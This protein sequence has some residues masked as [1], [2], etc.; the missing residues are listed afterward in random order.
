MLSLSLPTKHQVQERREDFSASL[1]ID[2]DA[3]EVDLGSS[4]SH[5]QYTYDLMIY[6]PTDYNIILVECIVNYEP[7]QLPIFQLGYCSDM[8]FS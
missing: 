6:L 8:R 3:T 4:T 5:I 2:K 1:Q 7:Q